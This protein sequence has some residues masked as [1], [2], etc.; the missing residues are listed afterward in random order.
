MDAEI[1]PHAERVDSFGSLRDMSFDASDEVAAQTA[2]LR[3]ISEAAVSNFLSRQSVIRRDEVYSR[4]FRPLAMAVEDKLDKSIVVTRSMLNAVKQF[5]GQHVVLAL[6]SNALLNFFLPSF[7]ET[8]KT[9]YVTFGAFSRP[10]FLT[11]VY[12]DQPDMP[13]APYD[14]LA[15]YI[16]SINRIKFPEHLF[17]KAG[18]GETVAVMAG[19]SDPIY[20]ENTLPVLS[21][22]EKD[23]P[24]EVV[25]LDFAALC[26]TALRGWFGTDKEGV[27]GQGKG[28]SL[29]DLQGAYNDAS[30]A[31]ERTREAM[32]C[33]AR[34]TLSMVPPQ[35]MSISGL[36]LEN[37]LRATLPNALETT[38]HR[39]M[40]SAR[41]LEA[42]FKK[43][44]HRILYACSERLPIRA[45]AV[46][47]AKAA[48]VKTVD[49][50]S[51]NSV[52]L[53]RYRPPAADYLTSIDSVTSCFL[54]E[55]YHADD[56]RVVCA[57]SPR[58]SQILDR[59][60]N[61]DTARTRGLLNIDAATGVVLYACQLQPIERSTEI[62]EAL[63]DTLKKAPATHL[64]VKLHRRENAAREEIYRET[65]TRSPVSDRVHLIFDEPWL[66][67]IANLM[68]V[69]NVV[70]SMY[71]NALREAACFGLPVIAADWFETPLPFDFPAHGLGIRA[72]SRHEMTDIVE[73]ILCGRGLDFYANRNDRYMRVNPQLIDGTAAR[74]IAEIAG[75]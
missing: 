49:V 29:L 16:R 39:F 61:S 17:K 57:G 28:V 4:Y 59:I 41:L 10:G 3:I 6:R 23:W 8:G 53:P 74:R 72:S 21:E 75:Y 12:G 48:G 14:A 70:V 63:L 31:T 18:D 11:T 73:D 45:I 62:L 19:F 30:E 13:Q 22:L 7:L 68:A 47:A 5:D 33:L 20:V 44:N 40:L 25:E 60:R 51:V 1:G 56:K 42:Y 66:S 71:S 50:M 24:V 37:Y 2:A 55:Y 64:L 58:M 26:A 35:A 46:E 69:S 32:T 15:D 38:L 34:E 27:Y 54:N 9:F 52:R 67:D 43:T 65:V 36:D